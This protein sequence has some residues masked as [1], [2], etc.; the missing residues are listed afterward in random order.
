MK[1]NRYN[2][3]LALLTI[4][5]QMGVVIFGFN[6]IGVF[7]DEKYQTHYIQKISILLGVFVALYFVIKQV[8]QINK[9]EK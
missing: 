6:Y 7:L 9:G 1:N 4:P 5:F 2:K 3:W 8:N